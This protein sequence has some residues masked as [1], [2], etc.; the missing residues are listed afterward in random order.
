MIPFWKAYRNT[1]CRCR[2]CG[3]RKKLNRHPLEYRI[4]PMCQCGARSW[5]KDEYRHRVER[6]QMRAKQGRY[7]ICHCDGL[8]QFKNA[9]PHRIGCKQCC[10]KADGEAKDMRQME[11]DLAYLQGAGG[12]NNGYLEG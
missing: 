11:A 2:S 10:Y 8:I 9:H 1:H 5:R 7:R 3:A 6:P 4:Q 12:E